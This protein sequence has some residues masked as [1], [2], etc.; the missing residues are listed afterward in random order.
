MHVNGRKF[1]VGTFDSDKDAHDAYQK[2]V[3]FH[4]AG[5]DVF[6][7]RIKPPKRSQYIG[8]TRGKTAKKWCAKRRINNR[9]YHIGVFDTE[10]EAHNAYINFK[11]T[12]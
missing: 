4:D 9:E 1:H 10:L 7:L 3:A 2:A 5:G 11:P 6:K 8:V 12:T